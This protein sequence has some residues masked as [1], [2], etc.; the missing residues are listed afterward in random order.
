MQL[1]GSFGGP[2]G[3]PAKD[4]QTQV[5]GGGIEGV[6]GVVEGEAEILSGVERAGPGAQLLGEVLVDLLGA[7][8]VGAGQCRAVQRRTEAGVVELGGN[9]FEASDQIA[10]ASATGELGEGHPRDELH[11]L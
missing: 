1:N 11:E 3:G 9:S 7:P 5:D 4:G 6:D 10:Q 8:L 2:E